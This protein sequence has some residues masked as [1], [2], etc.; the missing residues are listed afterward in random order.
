MQYEQQ[1]QNMPTA[2]QGDSSSV[3]PPTGEP[4]VQT[5]VGEVK[6]RMSKK[7][8]IILAIVFAIL[9]LG[10][11]GAAAYYFLVVKPGQTKQEQEG[12][13]EEVSEVEE[14][15]HGEAEE[16]EED[17]SAGSG[18]ED[19]V[20]PYAGWQT[21]DNTTVGVSFQYPT[22]WTVTDNCQGQSGDCSIEVS[23]GNYIWTLLVDP[24][25]TG[26]GFG[27]LIADLPSDPPSVYTTVTP[28]GYNA[29]MLNGYRTSTWVAQQLGG[30]FTVPEGDLWMNSSSFTN[31]DD[32]MNSLGFG[33][34]VM[35][36]QVLGNF[37]AIKYEYDIQMDYANLRVKGSAE[38]VQK[39]SEMDLITNSII[40]S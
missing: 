14:G 13:G 32:L 4:Q 29:V 2:S 27:F 6:K 16:V 20:N 1:G 17:P 11:G 3:Q 26:G 36:D 7:M 21:F 19:E 31:R 23:N 9:V 34:G 38:L 5:Q 12:D 22:G 28:G 40:L 25:I 30:E 37:F 35:Y 24:L 18:R 33:S 39:L 10:G 8:L 15:E